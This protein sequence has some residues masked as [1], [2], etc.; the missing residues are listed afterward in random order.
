MNARHSNEGFVKILNR[1]RSI[2]RRF[3]S[4][5]ANASLR[6][7]SN[8]SDPETGAKVTA[9]IMLAEVRR[10]PTYKDPRGRIHQD[11][12]EPLVKGPFS[13]TFTQQARNIY[14]GYFKET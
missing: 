9:E 10:Q 12:S 13:S 8:V 14:G 1:L 4:N 5:I 7:I 11:Y 3:E 6:E 2:L